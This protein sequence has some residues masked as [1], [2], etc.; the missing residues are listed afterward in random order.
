MYYHSRILR[1]GEWAPVWGVNPTT[2]GSEAGM[3]TPTP[4]ICPGSRCT[5]Q[6]HHASVL[7]RIVEGIPDAE[8]SSGYSSLTICQ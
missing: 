7:T 5:C 1:T 4:T 3:P 2:A 8:L 6:V